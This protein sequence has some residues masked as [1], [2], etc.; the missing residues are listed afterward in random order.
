MS[1]Q[2]FDLIEDIEE[3]ISTLFFNTLKQRH[4]KD[5]LK[6]YHIAERILALEDI[7][8]L[9]TSLNKDLKNG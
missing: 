9:L 8:N 2:I 3:Q 5:Y 7:K 6:Q 1:E 4:D